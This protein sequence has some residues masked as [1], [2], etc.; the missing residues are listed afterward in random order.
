VSGHI[1][2][3]ENY[4]GFDD[5]PLVALKSMEIF[6]N[7]DKSVSELFEDVPHLVATPEIILSTPDD[8]KFSIIDEISAALSKDYE[9]STIDGARAQFEN[10]WGL[11]RASNTQPAIT[12]RFEAYTNAQLVEYMKRFKALLDHHTEIDQSKFDSVMGQF[13]A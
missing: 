5:A 4:Y 2:I 7:S 13:S 12:L 3:G 11:V 8:V 1:F 6:A 10:G 9:V